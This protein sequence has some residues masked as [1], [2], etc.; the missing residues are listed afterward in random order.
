MKRWSA[1]TKLTLLYA[2]FMILLTCAALA[3]LFSLS[4]QEILSSVQSKLR[5]QV[6]ESLEDIEGSEGNL[7]I[8]SDFYTL[9]EGVYLSVY[10]GQDGEFLYGMI[11]AGFDAQA[12]FMPDGLQTIKGRN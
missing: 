7:K 2:A 3:I 5:E 8:D 10:D 4:N 6:E 9:E 11:P 1:K 12:D